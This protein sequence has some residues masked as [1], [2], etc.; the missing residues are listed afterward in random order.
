[1]ENTKSN[2]EAVGFFSYRKYNVQFTE[3]KENIQK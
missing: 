2:L 1:M 3:I